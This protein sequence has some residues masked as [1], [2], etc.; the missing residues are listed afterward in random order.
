MS[1]ATYSVSGLEASVEILVDSWGIPHIY[2]SSIC[3]VFFAQ[4]FNAARDRLWQIDLW[5]RRGLGLLSEVFGPAYAE[6]DRAARLF[7]YRGGMREEWLAYGSDTE[8]IIT[9]FVAGINAY[10]RLVEQNPHLLPPEFRLIGYR[11]ALWSPEDVVR[12]RSHGLYRNVVEEA[13]R[14]LVLR[15]FGSEAEAL[16]RRL[17]P[18]REI[19][20]PEGLTSP[21]Y[22]KTSSAS[23]SWPRAL[24]SLR[25]KR[26]EAT[27]RTGRPLPKRDK[28]GARRVATTGLSPRNAPQRDVRSSLTL[29]TATS[30][31]PPCA[32]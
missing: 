17:E 28:E 7:L 2:A 30:P 16:R 31:C 12:I 6:Q 22:L 29:P 23:T 10:M 15:D 4:G 32:T 20:I 13:T 18:H 21:S 11:P 27:L 1:P 19:V 26:R 25:E 9:A 3:D 5:R 8:R 24:S 14:A